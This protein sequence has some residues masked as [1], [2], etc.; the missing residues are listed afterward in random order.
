[1]LKVGEFSRLSQ[2]TVA[3][4]H[5]YDAIGLLKPAHTDPFTNY[6]YYAV[7]Q[8]TDIHRIMVLKELG[9]GLDQ[10]SQFIATD[11]ST[12]QLRGMLRLR[13]AEQQ[14][15]VAESMARLARIRFHL[16]QL[17]LGTDQFQLDVRL[18]PIKPFQALT[19]RHQ[20]GSHSEIPPVALDVLATLRTHD[21]TVAAP[22]NYFIYGDDY[23]PQDIDVEFVI[24]IDNDY[25][26]GDLPLTTGGALRVR[27]VAGIDEAAT[28]LFTGSPDNVT[29]ELVDLQRWVVANGYRLGGV[30]RLVHLRGPVERLPM[31]DWVIEA[32]HPLQPADG[33]GERT[34]A[35]DEASSLP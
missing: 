21:V 4:L 28:Y 23:R 24:P 8:L 10:I 13:E 2:V 33:S 16:R 11:L 35:G 5:H 1:M 14:Q 30:I 20:F 7:E 32:Q 34:T 12:D 27:A 29:H 25:P 9:L 6:R 26:G 31:N 19:S 18:K 17:E 22:I 3:T 15:R